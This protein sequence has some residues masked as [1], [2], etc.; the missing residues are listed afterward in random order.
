MSTRLQPPPPR[1]MPAH[2]RREIRTALVRASHRRRHP[3]RWLVALPVA[4]LAL[5]LGLGL[6]LA[7]PWEVGPPVVG[8][9]SPAPTGTAASTVPTPD[10]G[11]STPAPSPRPAVPAARPT[12][13]GP[14]S[15]AAR[16][17][18]VSR[19]LDGLGRTTTVATLHFAR[20]TALSGDAVVFEGRDGVAYA[21]SD[22]GSGL[23]SGPVSKMGDLPAP[24][25]K[26][27][28]VLVDGEGLSSASGQGRV[29]A[30]TSG[31]YRVTDAVASL[32]SRLVVDGH[33][34][35]WFEASRSDGWAWTGA[36]LNYAGT[37]PRRLPGV[38][39]RVD[40]RAFDAAGDRLDVDRT[41]R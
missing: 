16:S 18:A 1:D 23:I 6:G 2:R 9:P 25:A 19:C 24:D 15:K 34:G 37:I 4:V 35:A 40:V 3:H 11:R 21:C 32:Q 7:R 36:S 41:P 33:A 14:L 29:D 38:D 8:V 10:A 30:T 31:A 17:K 27:P 13:L 20:R 28:V 39:F 26:H 12:D 5:L 22:D